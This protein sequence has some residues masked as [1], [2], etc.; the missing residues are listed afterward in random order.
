MSGPIA[1]TR[2]G[3]L[4][5]VVEDGVE[6]FRGIPFARAPVG[7]RRFAPPERLEA[8]RGTRDALGF[9]AAP[10]QR[11]DPLSDALGLLHGCAI[12]E[13][14]LH[15]NV[16]TPGREGERPVLVW[17]QGGAFLGGTACVPLYDGRRLAAR[18]D[19][20][21]VTFNY[22][23][24]ALG[25]SVLPG[26]SGDD[27]VANVGLLDQVAALRW[28][29]RN[30]RAFGGDPNRVTAFGESAGAGSLL[31]LAGAPAAEGL[32]QRAIVQSAA[33]K[34]ILTLDEARERTGRLLGRLAPAGEVAVLE[35]VAL[36]ALLEAQSAC[37]A[38]GPHRTGMFYTPVPDGRTLTTDPFL[39]FG[40]GWARDVDLLIGTTRDEMGLYHF[41]QPDSDEGVARILAPQLSA[42]DATRVEACEAILS[43]FRAA[44][45]ARGESTAP[46]D[47]FLAIQTELSLRFHATQIAEARASDE[48]TWMYLFT[49]PSPWREGIVGACHALDLPFVFG[50]LDAPGMT[51]FTGGGDAARSL[52]EK[53]MDAWLAFARDGRP[54]HAGLGP[55]PHYDPEQRATMELGPECGLRLAPRE[56]ERALLAGLA[57][58]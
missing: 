35:S 23:V 4:R 1:E 46:C 37:V 13:D 58:V 22:R 57:C 5:G 9:G 32:F 55:W 15:V 7:S 18:G 28:V 24:G 54:E 48:N 39:A 47:L 56:P 38:S 43:G 27:A 51:E 29:R 26:F 31:A 30:A 2:E 20:V 34:G 40:R 14:C 45:A 17:I 52:S 44:R 53:M 8:W 41:G 10:P 6:I 3:E 42:Q 11:R 12:D 16:Y 36:D 49:W 19:V 33:P 50:N 25:W 21:V